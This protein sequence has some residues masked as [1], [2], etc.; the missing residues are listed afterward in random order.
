MFVY[1]PGGLGINLSTADTVIIY[2][3]DWNPHSDLQAMSRAH[4]IGQTKKVGKSACVCVCVCVCVC[5]CVCVLK[6]KTKKESVSLYF[7]PFI[8]SSFSF[9]V[10]IYKFVTLNS[11]EEKIIQ[12][13][14]SKMMLDQVREQSQSSVHLSKLSIS[15]MISHIS[16]SACQA[17]QNIEEEI[18]TK[19]LETIIK[20]GAKVH[21]LVGGKISSIEKLIY[22]FI[23]FLKSG[24]V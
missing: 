17:L 10:M 16:F 5:I 18:S 8:F 1:L 11:I 19:D 7:C 12:R 15:T 21:T 20:F 3:A 22:L 24:F 2:D 13:A 6:F 14:K 9:Q 23:Y 4:R